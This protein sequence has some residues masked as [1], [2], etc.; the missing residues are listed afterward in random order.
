MSV[1]WRRMARAQIDKPADRLRKLA[2]AVGVLLG[3]L[4]GRLLWMQ[5]WQ[6][7]D[8]QRLAEQNS[9]RVVPSRAPR[10]L[11]LD[12]HLKVLAANTPSL[13]AGLIPADFQRAKPEQRAQALELLAKVLDLDPSA[14]KVNLVRQSRRP[15]APLRLAGPLEPA[16]VARL[17]E[18]RSRLPGLVI[19]QD[20]KRSYSDPMAAHALGYVGEIRE[21]QLDKLAG[22]GYRLGD[23]IGQSGVEGVYDV[24]LKGRDGGRQVRI[25]ARG[26]E[27]GVLREIPAEPGDN[28]VL[29][30]DA[31][32]QKVAEAAL[33]PNAGS[34]VA[35]DPR[36]G[37]IL[38]LASKP[39]YSLNDFAGRIK[40][41]LWKA[42]MED[43][44]T[45]LSNRAIQGLYPPGSVFKFVTAAAGLESGQITPDWQAECL[46]IHWI[47]TWPYRCWK[48]I[49]H[50]RIS[51]E[52]AIVESCDIFFYNVGLQIKV[53]TLH[54]W[55]ENF[56]FGHRS[57]VD[58]RS[59]AAG[60]V[61]DAVWKEQTQHMPWFPGNTVMMSIGQGY[62]LAT[63]MQLAVA[64]SALAN[65]GMLVT[66]H[67]LKQVT[68]A[69]GQ[70][71]R[72]NAP[73][74]RG[75]IKLSSETLRLIQRAM[76]RAVDDRR[77]TAWRA[78][79]AGVS[80]AGKTGTAQNPHGED[81]AAFV[82][83]APV[84]NPQ[85]AIAVLVENGGEGGLTAAPIARAVMEAYFG[86]N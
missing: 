49:G 32:L 42:L 65:G 39:D 19:M 74:P 78:R 12:R 75:K 26:R 48:E 83:F 51:I 55:A 57:G 63:P 68:T 44:R 18:L 20:S 77:G 9:V 72:E 27:L 36:N 70:L 28:L 71:I 52:Q 43:E 17:E 76:T 60:L 6:G 8:Y 29:T 4:L 53:D 67:L 54:D 15:Y 50:G 2:L 79:V 47:S 7:Q 21:H 82:C 34:V 38:V 14:L 45:P 1:F 64:T 86:V 10:G 24:E 59:E 73:A 22:H 3:A 13:A 35:L 80:V 25:N 33:G 69:S 41:E 5:I 46:G 16:L 23:L 31:N 66:P 85:I 37:E 30:L 62:L 11:I 40:S 56:G 58:L 84:E 81:H 61:P